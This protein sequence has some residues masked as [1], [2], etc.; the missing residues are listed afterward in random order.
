MALT[1][2]VANRGKKMWSEEDR[3][4]PPTQEYTPAEELALCNNEGRSHKINRQGKPEGFASVWT[5]L[6]SKENL[7]WSRRR[8][9]QD[10]LQMAVPFLF[11]RIDWSVG[12]V[13]IGVNLLSW[14]NSI[15]EKVSY[16]AQVTIKQWEMKHHYNREN[17]GLNL[18]LPP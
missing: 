13:F 15:L 9:A 14:T 10:L 1:L 11:S 5:Q 2:L 7:S 18:K 3:R 12:S 16:A 6:P 8:A 17:P 4:G